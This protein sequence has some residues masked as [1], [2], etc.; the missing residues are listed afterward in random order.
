VY[1]FMLRTEEVTEAD[2]GEWFDE[3]QPMTMADELPLYS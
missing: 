2:E 1:D 3:A